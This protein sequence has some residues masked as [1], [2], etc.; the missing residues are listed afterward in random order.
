[1]AKPDQDVVVFLG[2]GSYLLNNTDIYSSVLYDQKLI[3]VLCDNGGHMVINR[4]Q[5]A[6]G[7]KEYICNLRAARA[8]NLQFVDFE[9][10]AKSLGANAETVSSTSE[11]EAAYKRAKDSDKTYVIVIK[12]H[13]YEWLEGSAFWESPTLQDPITKENKDALADFQGGKE[14]QRKGV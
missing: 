3:I 9:N 2:D 5:L 7:G 13:G 6:K 10:H 11:L 12:T 8:T 4:L 1:M 14:K